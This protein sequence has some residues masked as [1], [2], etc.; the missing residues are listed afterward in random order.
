MKRDPLDIAVGVMLVLLVLVGAPYAFQKLRAAA[1]VE[2]T[3]AAEEVAPS[4]RRVT[5]AVQGMMCG[6]CVETITNALQGTPGVMGCE[7]DMAAERAV[8]LCD[9]S[10]ADSAL[11]GAIERSDSLYTA[12]VTGL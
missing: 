8:V 10:V 2:G 11:V 12:H 7:V 9:R 3:I 6:T 5:L 1:P 4:E